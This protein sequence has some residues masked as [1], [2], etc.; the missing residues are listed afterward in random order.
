[1]CSIQHLFL[2]ALKHRSKNYRI[3]TS[4]FMNRCNVIKIF[5]ERLTESSV[6]SLS[7]GRWWIIKPQNSKVRQKSSFRHAPYSLFLNGA[8]TRVLRTTVKVVAVPFAWL[9]NCF[10]L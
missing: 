6:P 1:M 7:N 8:R 10:V 5:F 4:W 3:V 9:A 2:F